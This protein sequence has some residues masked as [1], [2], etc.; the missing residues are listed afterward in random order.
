MNMSLV[1][2]NQEQQAQEKGAMKK[3]EALDK[4]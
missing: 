3:V 2:F 4:A 1:D